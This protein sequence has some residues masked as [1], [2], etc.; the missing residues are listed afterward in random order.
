MILIYVPSQ[1]VLGRSFLELGVR[2]HSQIGEWFAVV[3][4]VPMKVKAMS[5]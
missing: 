1:Q 4:N 2:H 5:C 3:Q